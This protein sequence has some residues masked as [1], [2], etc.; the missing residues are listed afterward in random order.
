MGK[1]ARP[2]EIKATESVMNII[3]AY[4]KGDEVRTQELLRRLGSEIAKIPKGKFQVDTSDN[5][6]S[7]DN[8]PL[9]FIRDWKNRSIG[10]LAPSDMVELENFMNKEGH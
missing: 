9:S 7:F 4:C 2:F 3:R 1:Y 5:Y 6:V 10:I 8:I